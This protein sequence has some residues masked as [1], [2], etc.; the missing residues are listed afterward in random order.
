MSSNLSSKIHYDSQKERQLQRDVTPDSQI[1]ADLS[2]R[3][4]DNGGLVKPCI[5]RSLSEP[6]LSNITPGKDERRSSLTSFTNETKSR[7]LL[8][9]P[10]RRNLSGRLSK[11]PAKGTQG[12]AKQLESQLRTSRKEDE[13]KAV[14]V[15]EEPS[16]KTPEHKGSRLSASFSRYSRHSRIL[17]S[18][19]PS[20]GTLNLSNGATD[21]LETASHQHEYRAVVSTK[22]DR[23]ASPGLRNSATDD[24]DKASAQ[25]QSRPHRYASGLIDMATNDTASSPLPPVPRLPSATRS[26]SPASSYASSERPPTLPKSMSFERLQNSGLGKQRKRDELWSAFRALDNEL[27]K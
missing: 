11:R 20:S 14:D 2:G 8:S 10:L 13:A 23:V 19:P 25:W 4:E 9:S 17:L 16:D 21:G 24:D 7:N 27:Y 15:K 26:S 18:R 5:Q 6:F 22:S 3:T 1:R 12:S